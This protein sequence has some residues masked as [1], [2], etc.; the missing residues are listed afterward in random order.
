MS[1][2]P[3]TLRAAVESYIRAN[4]EVLE[5]QRRAAG[6]I[7]RAI[8]LRGSASSWALTCCGNFSQKW[9]RSRRGFSGRPWMRQC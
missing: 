4:P 7:A 9:R 1:Y 8:G 6:I 2:A 5:N 3:G